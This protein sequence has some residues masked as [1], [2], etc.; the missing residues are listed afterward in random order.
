[1]LI[2]IISVIFVFGLIVLVHEFGHMIAAKACGVAVPDFAIGMGPSLVSRK[3]GSTRYH[4]CA[5]P[6]GGFVRIEG[7]EG[8]SSIEAKSSRVRNEDGELVLEQTDG[9]RWSDAT[10]WQKALMLF[11]GP[12]MNLVLAAVVVLAMGLVGFPQRMVMVSYIEPG[13]PAEE[14]GM[15]PGDLITEIGGKKVTTSTQ[16]S[17]LVT[18]GGERSL[19]VQVIR[20]D[21]EIV[22]TVHPRVMPDFN[23]DHISLGIATQDQDYITT[24]IS[25]V[26]PKTAGYRAGL[27]IGDRVVSVNGTEPTTGFD[28]MLATAFFDEE[29]NPVDQDLNPIPE[30]APP[31][32]LGV[33][34]SGEY[35]EFELPATTT[36][37][38]LGV[39]FKP[40]LNRLPIGE[41]VQRS[42]LDA[43]NM[44]LGMFFGI[45]MM[46]SGEGIKSIAG[47]V[48]IASVI[49]QSAQSGWYTFLQIIM[50]ININLA[51]LNLLPLPALDGG[52]LVFVALNGIGIR[53]RE[54]REAMVHAVGMV[55]LLGLIGLVTFTDV[56]AFF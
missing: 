32:V 18:A 9:K 48:G 13:S 49:G 55:M 6:I 14:S 30:D 29:G 37:I 7:L 23:D 27:K 46:F 42:M 20:G 41:S 51:L 34:R 53:I 56:L 11:A 16:L 22:L 24:E 45:R 50:L 33:D 40:E 15:H 44:M 26:Q 36:M 47:P 54:E 10:G 39:L 25:I 5:L 19:P 2:S 52:R 31:L 38:D 3:W 1:M 17:A 12:A 8:D 35:L 21:D 4:I 43:K 28:V